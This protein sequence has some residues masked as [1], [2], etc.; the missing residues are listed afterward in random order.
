[1]SKQHFKLSP[2]STKR[3][4]NCPASIPASEGVENKSSRD[5]DEG[6]KA[7]DL[8]EV[9]L[10][11]EAKVVDADPEMLAYVQV[12][13][14][15]VKALRREHKLIAEQIEHTTACN[16]IEWLGGTADWYGV[17]SENGECVLHLVDLKYGVGVSVEVEGNDQ[18][19]SYAVIL[20]SFYPGLIDR[21]KFTIIQ[22]RA[23]DGDTVREWSCSA[24]RVEQHKAQ[25]VE[26]V[27]KIENKTAEFKAGDHC[28]W[29]P[30]LGTCETARERALEVAKIEFND[31]VATR[32][33]EELVRLHEIGPSI[34]TLLDRVSDELLAM[35]RRGVTVPGY[36]AVESLGHRKW[37]GTTEEILKKLANRKIGKKIATEV[38]LK[39]PSQLEKD[40]KNK[41]ITEGLT[42][43]PIVG[44]KVVPISAKGDPVD[45][46]V[47]EFAAIESSEDQSDGE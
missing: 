2:S 44:M 45:F 36:K 6:T 3:W 23:L 32:N 39:S 38:T 35:M 30:I 28:R 22:P 16:D 7:H 19:L 9:L 10:R 31:L 37:D 15:Y 17:Y 47:T 12:Y 29:C 1:M 41:K 5:A 24:E 33:V 14:G 25:I 8:G 18:L 4:I 46:A 11:G 34:K 13:V 27:Q 43:R 42:K 26:V 40:T 20:E 21:F